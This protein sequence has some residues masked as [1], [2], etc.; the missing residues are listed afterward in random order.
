M[1]GGTLIAGKHR[2]PA[3]CPLWQT[4]PINNP[5]A[6]LSCRRLPILANDE[7]ERKTKK[8]RNARPVETAAAMEIDSGGL[9]QF[10]LDDSHSCLKKPTQK[11]LRPSRVR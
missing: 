3:H 7:K 11:P 10:F 6:K 4:W 8:V 1:T 9:R 2:V 5:D